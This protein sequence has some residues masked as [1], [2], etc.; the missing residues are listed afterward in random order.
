M[1]DVD[2]GSSALF[3]G[4]D[5]RL[6]PGNTSELSGFVGHDFQPLLASRP[7]SSK[8]PCKQRTAATTQKADSGKQ[9]GP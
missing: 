9:C 4:D 2:V 5:F 1:T 6:E 3:G 8:D 7:K